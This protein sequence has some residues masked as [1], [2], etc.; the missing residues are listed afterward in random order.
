[1]S[2]LSVQPVQIVG[3]EPTLTVSVFSD[4]V[5]PSKDFVIGSQVRAHVEVLFPDGVGSNVSLSV[6]WLGS[7]VFTL[8]TTYATPVV[9][10]DVSTVP[11]E[12]SFIPGH[13]GTAF[14]SETF[15][16]VNND[17]G[18]RSGNWFAIDLIFEALPGADAQTSL[19]VQLLNSPHL[20][21]VSNSSDILGLRI[22]EVVPP[23]AALSTSGPVDAGDLVT[24]T[25]VVG[26]SGASNATAFGLTVRD[27]GL[28]AGGIVSGSARYSLLSV[29]VN[30]TAVPGASVG[31]S[32][33]GFGDA[34]VELPPLPAGSVSV[35]EYVVEMLGSVEA[36]ET[37]HPNV[38][39]TWRSHPTEVSRA[40]NTTV[41]SDSVVALTIRSPVVSVGVQTDDASPGNTTAL[42]GQVVEYSVRV[43]IPEGVTASARVDWSAATS[44]WPGD[45]LEDLSIVSVVSVD[46]CDVTN[47]NTNDLVG[48]WVEV[49]IRGR[50][51]VA[52]VVPPSATLSTSGPVDAGDLVT[53]TVVVGHSGASNATAFGLTVRDAGLVAGGIVSGSARYSLLSVAVNGTAV[54]GASVGTSSWGF[55]DAVVEL[56]PLPAG[57]V[58]VVEYVVEMLGSVE[59]GE[60]L[61][62]NVSVTWRSHPT[63]V[64]RAQNTT[65]AS[66]SVVAL[67]IRS[68]VVSV[69]VQ[70]DDASPGNTTALRGQVVE[71]SVR[72][73]IPEGVTASAPGRLVGCHVG[74]A[75]RRSR[76]LSIVSVSSSSGAVTTSCAGSGGSL[77]WLASSGRSVVRA[78]SVS[79]D[80]CD[81]TNTN[82]NDLVGEWVEVVIRGRVRL[83]VSR[84]AVVSPSASVSWLAD[85]VDRVANA[86]G[87][88][89]SVEVLVAEVVP[90]SATLST[91]GPVDAGDLVTTTVVVGHSGASNAT[92]FGL[93]VRDA[94]LV[95][96]GIVSGSARYSLLSVAV[97]GTAVPGA[98]VGTSSWGFGDAVV[99]L[100]PLPAG[101]VSVVE[102]VV[103]MLGSV[104]AG[105]T[106]HPSVSVTWRSHPTE[107][108][109][110]QNTTVASDSVVALTI[111]SPVV[112]VGVQTDDASPGNTTALRGQVVEYSV[113]VPIPEGVTA[114]ARVDWSAATSGWPGD[115]L[116]DLSIVS[117]SSSSGAVTTSCAGSGGSLGWLAS[118]G[119]SVVRARSVSVDMCDVTNTNTNDLV[120]EWVEVVIRG[121]VRL[122]VSRGAVV[123]PS[124]SVSWLADGVDRVANAT[125][126]SASVEV[127][128]AE[129]VPPSATLSTS[130]PVDAGDLVTTTV[131]VG[132]SGASNATAFGLTVRDA[133]L[134][135]GGIVS[136]SAR[137]SLLSVAVNGTAVP[138][139]SVGTS[140]WGFGDAVVELPPL[141]AGSVSVVEYV[142][143]ML[144]SVEAGE[145]LHPSVSV[146]WRSHPTEVSRAQNTT[147]AS[148]SVVA[149]TIRSPV[150]SVGVQTDDASPGNTT[151]L[152][153]QVVEYSVRVP[154]PEGVTASARVD[155][156]AAT[157]GWPGDALEDLS[158][159]SVSSS[160]GA[161]TT[162]CAGSGGSL[163][164]LA[165][166]GRSVVRA[167]SVSVDMCDV[168]NTNTNDLVGEWVEV[169]IR[170]RVR[171]G[172][173]RGAVVSPS[174]SVS[175]LADGVDRVANATGSSASVEVLVAEAVP[176]SAT[177]STSGPVDA[178][179]LVTTTVVVGHSGASNAT[180]FGL[181][182]RDAGLVAGG[183]VSGSARY[184]L[185]QVETLSV[186]LE[187]F[188]KDVASANRGAMFAFQASMHSL[189]EQLA[190]ADVSFAIVEPA[191]LPLSVAPLA[192]TGVDAMDSIP[193]SVQLTLQALA[194]GLAFNS[195][196]FESEVIS[197]RYVPE[198]V[199]FSG[200]QAVQLASL[201]SLDRA[202][203]ST[204]LLML[205]MGQSPL[206]LGGGANF[207]FGANFSLDIESNDVTTMLTSANFF[208]HFNLTRARRYTA[209]AAAGPVF[210]HAIPVLGVSFSGDRAGGSAI[211][212]GDS[213]VVAGEVALPNALSSASTLTVFF[214]VS[215]HIT[216][217]D[218]AAVSVTASD[219]HVQS[220]CSGVFAPLS[221]LPPGNTYVDGTTIVVALCTLQNSQNSLGVSE[222]TR[223]EASFPV[224]GG[225]AG[226]S[227]VATVNFTSLLVPGIN[228]TSDALTLTAPSLALSNTTVEVPRLAVD[229]GDLIDVIFSIFHDAN[230]SSDAFSPTL[231]DLNFAASQYAVDSV[232]VDGVRVESVNNSAAAARLNVGVS[233]SVDLVAM[234]A[235]ASAAFRP[236]IAAASVSPA[237][238]DMVDVNDILPAYGLQPG[239]RST[240]TNNRTTGPLEYLDI[241]PLD[242]GDPFVSFLELGHLSNSTASAWNLTFSSD[243]LSLVAALSPPEV[244]V[245]TSQSVDGGDVVTI[246]ATVAHTVNSN[247][248]AFGLTVRD[249][250][251]VAGGIV[252]GSARYSLLSVAVNGTAVPGASVGTSSWGF[253]DAVVELPPLPAGSVSVVEY[254]VEMLGSVEAGETLHPNVS[255]DD[256]SPGNTTALRGQVVEYS[257]RV[258]IP[259]GVTASA[260]VD[261]SAATSGWPGDALEDLSIVSVSSSSGAVTTSCAG[262]GG[263]LGWLASSGR[264]VVRARSVSV[265]M[266]DVTNT[267]T[268]DLVGEWV[269]VVIRGRVRLGV[270]RGA[271][272]SPSASVSWLA[273][274]VDRV[275]NATGSSA[276][277]E[278]GVE[279]DRVRLTVRDA[280]LVAGGIVSGSARYSLLSVAVNGTAVPGASVGTS[281]W[282]FGDAV[283][284]LPPLPAGSVSVVEYVVEMLGSVE[285]GETLHPNVSVTWRSHPTEVSR[286]QNTTVASDSVVALTIRSPVVSVGVQTDDASPGNTTALRGQVVEYSVRVPIPE[287][288][289]ASAR[290][291]WS[292]ATSG[293]PG[294][295]LEDLS[296]VSVSS[297][298][299]AV[300]TSC[301]GSGGSLGWLA[302]SGRSVVR[303]RSVS[304]DM[305][306]VTNTNTNDLVGEWVEVVI[307]GRVRLGVS[308]G[309]VV[310]PSASVSWLADGVDRVANATGS[311]ASV[312]VLVAEVV[313]PSAALS[314]S[315]PVDAGDLVTTTVVVGHSGASNATAFGLTVRDAGLVAGGIVSGSARYSLL[316]VAVNGTAVPGASVGT[317]S[318]EAGETLHPN[319]SVTW[320]SHPTEVS[321]AQNTTVASD[322]VV[323]LTIRSPVVSVGVQ[324]DDASPGNTT[325]LRGQVV[326]YSVRVPIP[327]GVTA[328]ARVDWSA[329]TSGW[330]GDALGDLSIVSVSSSSGA[331]TTSCAGSGGS[332]GWLASS[333]RSVV[334]ARSVSVDMCDVTNTNTN[335]L[336]GEWVEVVIRGRVRLGV[337]RG[338][339]VSPSASV[340]WLADGVDRVANATGSSASVE[341]LVAEVVPPSATLSTSG[342]VD[343]GTW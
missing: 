149:L 73:P 293:W 120:G 174:A 282:G 270:S 204:P 284:E 292:A 93:T 132:H 309:A 194:D 30:G 223:I 184:S 110:A 69:G 99:E 338:A 100:P 280:G 74:L 333:G 288:V 263:S 63:E 42:R 172:V 170:G 281:S 337:S 57:S 216:F 164:W 320:R 116:G 336:V 161:V 302:S 87:S 238:V 31:T 142:V 108:S 178:G 335:D 203:L 200:A 235:P 162:S 34:V 153:G 165:S 234:A 56:P 143:E 212:Q 124:A 255:T 330:P 229:G 169:V 308:R 36:G 312:E 144:G 159:V 321:R 279:R 157:S 317:S 55:G 314:T 64:S 325:A 252:S 237:A 130:G 150:V 198:D 242:A 25:V 15:T 156:S 269:E 180:A 233:S 66:D 328:S 208:S 141:P 273:D 214:T 43:P 136:G 276:S 304:V 343:A 259:E 171:L 168:T 310:S 11:S 239:R 205:G 327:E 322:S 342:P 122:G 12:I 287:G 249:A 197:G 334:R 129:V 340:S 9:G 177:L 271:V 8:V 167:R 90:P 285:A 88:S 224:Q 299:G 264:S 103:E 47:T 89:A 294:D 192:V 84:G 133:G 16:I 104:E 28:V 213:V 119:R 258:P 109:R 70:T 274:G 48:E 52:E 82:T 14:E 241:V 40:Q 76:D 195:T 210:A 68:P 236:S 50:V 3:A 191:L 118:S 18:L 51:L 148:D 139:A 26:H 54:P 38:S 307:R 185:L 138:G 301:A 97:N 245:N 10:P 217:G 67:T 226:S 20:V 339:V 329:A 62:P 134:V 24:T 128:V 4:G 222:A 154:I 32:S 53:T 253:G 44:G 266:C 123:S 72:V 145:T 23:S 248:P 221:L 189:G 283:V 230:S 326:E 188:V 196:L 113:R 160:S 158:I 278:R 107:V 323:A 33:W 206:Q 257:V 199:Q 260:R 111:R 267:N 49:V 246:S 13:P 209:V 140:S 155:W 179:D 243:L 21:D 244:S 102:Y 318:V 77:G 146:T 85:G 225:V 22:A 81:V 86:T 297:S 127:L 175:W 268:N 275:A 147:V 17:T 303:A 290:V 306:D 114:S 219:Q 75:G 250:G 79:V 298:S 201:S 2:T 207:T 173:S 311:S 291:D 151:A 5:L 137:Y 231:V 101:S 35:V 247:A 80:M 228:I 256:A 41:A 240:W 332:L 83:G 186:D 277:V 91:S 218:A 121:R 190:S 315:G 71:Y 58:S 202:A 251:L 39:V 98:S 232:E 95:A 131:V 220:N 37:L 152:R 295:A 96:G 59:A 163:G 183:I 46:M 187:F 319:V 262:S 7:P 316:S 94:G 6:A 45:A 265:D 105:E 1:M 78:R 341:V 193:V 296:I 166:S 106:L 286:A 27:A 92:A 181:T 61:H 261:W 29:A 289:T 182:V 60:T 254:V 211:V 176:P 112:S 125:G 324:T 313:P 126:S 19:L 117:V 115:A 135:A 65:V 227:V 215:G 305:C 331:V 272:V 300:T